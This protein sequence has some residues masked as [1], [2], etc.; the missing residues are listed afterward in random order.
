MRSSRNETGLK[1]G[2]GFTQGKSLLAVL[3]N[4]G[5]DVKNLWFLQERRDRVAYGKARN[6]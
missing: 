1:T 6:E 4:I 3:Q 5:G 2:S